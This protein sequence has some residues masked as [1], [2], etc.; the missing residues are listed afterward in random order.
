MK[1]AIL[2]KKGGVGKSTLCLLFYESLRNAGRSVAIRDWDPQGTTTKALQAFKGEPEIPGATYDVLFLDTPPNLAHTA[3]A[4]AVAEADI[5]LVVTTP[6][7][8]DLWEAEE[9]VRFVQDTNDNAL[10]RVVVN[11]VR[12]TTILGRNIDK[13]VKK[14]GISAQILKPKLSFREMYRHAAGEGW[15][16]LDMNARLEVA[17]LALAVTALR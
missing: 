2:A 16:A 5:A 12:S 7:L 10:V 15:K 9:A 17:Q 6:S 14:V 3:T 4:A 8:P 1:V 11:Q 13:A